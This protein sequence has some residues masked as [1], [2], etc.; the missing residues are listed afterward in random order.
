MQKIFDT[1]GK[2]RNYGPSTQEVQEG[3]RRKVE[4]KMRREAQEREEEE[5]REA[6]EARHRAAR[7]EEWVGTKR[8]A[9]LDVVDKAV[10]PLPAALL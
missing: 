7:W 3:N 8:R 9:G 5:Q 6:E 1:V 10:E 2:P 4:E